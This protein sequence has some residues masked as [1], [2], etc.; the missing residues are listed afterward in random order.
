MI[1]EG[2]KKLRPFENQPFPTEEDY[3]HPIILDNPGIIL[4]DD[5]RD[6][7]FEVFHELEIGSNRID[8][9]YVFEDG[10]ILIAEAKLSK[11]HEI[12]RKVIGQLIDYAS[13][14][15]GLSAKDVLELLKKQPQP[16][17]PF[18]M[19]DLFEKKLASGIRNKLIMAVVT[20]SNVTDLNRITGFL[21]GNMNR[22]VIC[23]V[24][25]SRFSDSG[26]TYV[27]VNIRNPN[28]NL[29]S[30]SFK[31]SMDEFTD[32]LAK[33]YS[34]ES[35]EIRNGLNNLPPGWNLYCGQSEVVVYKKKPDGKKRFG[36]NFNWEKDWINLFGSGEEYDKIAK[37]FDGDDVQKNQMTSSK[38]N[39]VRFNYDAIT[40][41]KILKIL[42]KL[43][44]L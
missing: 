29:P 24:E 41:E 40:T 34:A 19:G 38:F 8:F 17:M 25:I 1:Y 12:K 5:L 20:D 16:H 33:R 15:S 22:A 28:D 10:T 9:L 35:E 6:R 18:L 7:K 43:D 4:P 32:K 39:M 13:D 3:F 23:L 26:K 11:N 36:L 21:G 44:T 14:L 37:L 42:K 30:N 27:N 2:T 31:T